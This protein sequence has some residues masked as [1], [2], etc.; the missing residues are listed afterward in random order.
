MHCYRLFGLVLRSE[1]ALPELRE[2]SGDPDVVISLG[3][4]EGRP[5]TEWVMGLAPVPGGGVVEVR[6]IGRFG[7][8]GGNRIV[9]DPEP[10]VSDRNIRMYLLGSAIGALLHQRRMLPLHANAIALG[11]RAI[12]FAGRSGAGKSTLAAAFHDRGCPL[13]SDD[14]CV[15]TRDGAGKVE[16]QPGIPRVRL[17][18]DAVERSGRDAET[19]DPAFDGTAKY[20]LPVAEGHAEHPLPLAAIYILAEA[21]DFAIRPLNGVSA[22]KALALNT[23]RGAYVPVIGDPAVHFENCLRVAR[24]VPVFL[25]D[26]PWDEAR[27]A[28]TVDRVEAHLAGIGR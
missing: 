9:V 7:I 24:E 2:G 4:V 12:A 18:R 6:D 5:E 10:G 13:L 25:L 22:A 21:E 19:L 28:E 17:W 8:G 27:V 26:R 1:I 20:V 23:Y 11:D 16:A 15:L 14:I 3:K